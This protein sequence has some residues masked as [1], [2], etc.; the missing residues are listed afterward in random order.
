MLTIRTGRAVARIPRVGGGG[1]QRSGQAAF[2]ESTETRCSITLEVVM[3]VFSCML[4]II[5]PA[6]ITQHPWHH[7]YDRVVVSLYIEV[8]LT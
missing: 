1:T 5:K 8:V 3:V 7:A 4:Q 6:M 2:G